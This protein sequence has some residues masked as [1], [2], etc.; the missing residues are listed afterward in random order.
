MKPTDV[1]KSKVLKTFEVFFLPTL[2]AD[3][4]ENKLS[5]A[6]KFLNIEQNHNCTEYVVGTRRRIVDRPQNDLME[7]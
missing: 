1:N 2:F 7:K 5:T 6:P 4:T 3:S